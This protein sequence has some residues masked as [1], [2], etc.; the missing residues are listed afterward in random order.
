MT[1]CQ[2]LLTRNKLYIYEQIASFGV[3][4]IL[5]SKEAYLDLMF[6]GQAMDMISLRVAL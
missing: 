6:K 5:E 3:S 1:R 4:V 2:V